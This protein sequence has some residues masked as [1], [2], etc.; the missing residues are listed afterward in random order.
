[1]PVDVADINSLF[2]AVLINVIDMEDASSPLDNGLVIINVPTE[3]TDSIP[4]TKLVDK[5]DLDVISTLDTALVGVSVV[6]EVT[7]RVLV[8]VT[9]FKDISSLLNA[10]LIPVTDGTDVNSLTDVLA[11]L[12]V[13]TVLE[14][15]DSVSVSV[16]I[17]APDVIPLLDVVLANIIV[18]IEVAGR[19][20][21]LVTIL[22]DVADISSVLNAVL[23]DV[24]G[25]TDSTGVSSTDVVL[26]TAP[27]IL[28][29]TDSAFISVPIDVADVITLL[30][31]MLVCITDNAYVN[32]LLDL[33]LVTV[34]VVIE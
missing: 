21:V 28:E 19:V 8:L 5:A 34:L 7:E 9:I 31:V 1:M 3:V 16:L 22:E 23:V 24:V 15:T 30:D 20:L 11:T 33:V 32:S 29:M 18:E 14:M 25:V 17:G 26:V 13:T 27:V 4:I 12:T 10:V 2:D 6:T